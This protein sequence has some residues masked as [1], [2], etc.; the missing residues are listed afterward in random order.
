M[1]ICIDPGHGMSN[2]TL[3]VYDPGCAHTEN[4]FQFQE[5]SIALRYALA[6]K[7][8]FLAKK[9]DIF[10]TRDDAEDPAPV[11]LRARKAVQAQ[12]DVFISLHLNAYEGGD[13]AKGL[14]VL[15][16][17]KTDKGLAEQLQRALVSTI[18]LHDR[19]IKQRSDLAVLQFTGPAVL[20]EL[21]FLANDEDRNKLIDPQVRHLMANTIVEVI[22]DYFSESKL[23]KFSQAA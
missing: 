19:G 11:I 23:L 10:L 14:E 15:F 9:L 18:G 4:G 16:N 2:K 22:V 3:G 7:D 12:C 6:L 1:K 13:Q 20:I 8:A 21:G 17:K 5:A